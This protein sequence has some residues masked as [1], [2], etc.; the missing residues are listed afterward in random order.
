M[1]LPF[2]GLSSEEISEMY[3]SSCSTNEEVIPFSDLNS[4]EISENIILACSSY[5]EN[6]TSSISGKDSLFWSNNL[7]SSG[8]NTISIFE[9]TYYKI[10]EVKG[11][12][13]TFKEFEEYVT[14]SFK[15]CR[16]IKELNSI[17]DDLL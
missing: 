10:R 17:T 5:T 16:S 15:S 6:N 9:K 13:F 7:S 4:E 14:D 8:K 11:A 3:S 2:S 1:E 12:F